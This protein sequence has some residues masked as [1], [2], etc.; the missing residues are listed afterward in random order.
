MNVTGV[1]LAGGKSS[2]MGTDKGLIDLDGKPMITHVI[3]VLQKVASK[4]IIIANNPSYNQFN[5]EVY[6][7]LFP[8]KGPVGGIYTAL[9][10]SKTEKNI[11]LSC[12]TPFVNEKLLNNLLLQSKDYEITVSKFKNKIHPLIGV[13]SQSVKTI[14]EENLNKNRLKL[15]LVNQ[16]TELNIVHYNDCDFDEKIFFNIN[17]PTELK[18]CKS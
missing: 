11:I 8:E 6:P 15:G 9:N 7:D 4:V 3:N 17:T 12:D 14:F 2:R 1:I 5:L 13:Y 10:C 16:Q 18:E